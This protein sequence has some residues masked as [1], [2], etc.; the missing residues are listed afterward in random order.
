VVPELFD[1]PGSGWHRTATGVIQITPRRVLTVE[2]NGP[3]SD[4]DAPMTVAELA[5]SA[6]R[7]VGRPVT[8]PGEPGWMSRFTDNTRHATEYRR[9]RVL[10]AGDAAHVHAPFGGQGLNLG[11]QDAVN[12]GWKLAATVRGWAPD[13]LLDTYTAERHPV[14]AEVLANTRAQVALMNPDPRITPLR[15]LFAELMAIEPV[16]RHL[17]DLLT[18]LRVR[19]DLPA[20]GG[21]QHAL[22]GA[23]LPPLTLTV[24]DRTV[25]ARSLLAGGRPVLLDLADSHALRE[26]ARGWADRVTLRTAT[27]RG[28]DVPALLVRPDGYVAWVGDLGSDPRPVLKHWFG[29]ATSA[30][31][32]G[33]PE[34]LTTLTP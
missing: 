23:F 20:C 25:E 32:E 22:L 6:S 17:G 19:Y 16:N 15:E 8:I 31:S 27:A 28:L 18:A 26:A 30:P 21:Q 34:S 14:A 1:T 24:A 3:P 2:F 11:L 7:V 12:L 29:T 13:D 5:A 9:G 10:L 4:R 33:G